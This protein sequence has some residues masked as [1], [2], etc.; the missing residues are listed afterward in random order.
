MKKKEVVNSAHQIVSNARVKMFAKHV[1]RDSMQKMGNAQ[2]SVEMESNSKHNVMMEI[3][4]MEMVVHQN[5]NWKEALFVKE[6]LLK[7][8]MSAVPS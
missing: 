3:I 2:K 5:A 8:K 4:R 7:K 6:D 1:E